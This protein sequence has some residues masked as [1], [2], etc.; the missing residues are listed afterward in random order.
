VGEIVSV[1]LNVVDQYIE[2]YFILLFTKYTPICLNRF[3]EY[4]TGVLTLLAE[5]PN[6]NYDITL[7]ATKA[8]F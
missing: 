8:Q 2:I 5:L 4:N 7:I 3:V 6:E 1:L